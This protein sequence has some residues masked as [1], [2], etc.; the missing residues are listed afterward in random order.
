MQW[1]N[2]WNYRNVNFSSVLASQ[3]QNARNNEQMSEPHRVSVWSRQH[4][5]EIE[6]IFSFNCLVA[7]ITIDWLPIGFG[8]ADETKRKKNEWGTKITTK[9]VTL[10]NNQHTTIPSWYEY[11]R[12]ERGK[13]K[14]NTFAFVCVQEIAIHIQAVQYA[15][16]QSQMTTKIA[17]ALVRNALFRFPVPPFL[18]NFHT[19]L[20][21]IS[22]V[23]S[24]H[25]RD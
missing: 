24:M 17:C 1:G 25:G 2:D 15:Y 18:W 12:K 7:V 6:E 14:Q 5:S 11:A 21:S 8:I 13:E 16:N 4:H 3:T 10:H 20:V 9:T 22:L 23:A 19:K